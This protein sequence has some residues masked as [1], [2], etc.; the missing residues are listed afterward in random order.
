MRYK[1]WFSCTLGFLKLKT[2]QRPVYGFDFDFRTCLLMLLIIC[3]KDF[4]SGFFT[5]RTKGAGCWRNR[6]VVGT[7]NNQN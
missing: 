6:I 4:V 2:G 3:S 5:K 1:V 7:L